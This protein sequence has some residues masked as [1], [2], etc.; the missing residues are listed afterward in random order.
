MFFL[1]ICK[2]PGPHR[3]T[4]AE[5]WWTLSCSLELN[6][7]PSF[8]QRPQKTLHSPPYL[9]KNI[10]LWGVSGSSARL[11]PGFALLGRTAKRQTQLLL[12]MW[13][14]LV[15]RRD[16]DCSVEAG[17][18]RSV[19]PRLTSVLCS[20]LERT[21]I[22]PL[23]RNVFPFL[24][25]TKNGFHWKSLFLQFKMHLQSIACQLVHAWNSQWV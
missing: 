23:I 25:L 24:F 12:W 15:L 16:I 11:G 21:R 18:G 20:G 2:C 22:N 10:S 7:W 19:W 1:V 3:I 6:R 9:N 5:F 4:L 8:P 17:M 14:F 13:S